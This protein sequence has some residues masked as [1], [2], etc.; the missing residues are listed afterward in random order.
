MRRVRK[1][2]EPPCLTACRRELRPEEREAGRIVA[3]DWD[4]LGDCA[5]NVRSALTHDQDFLCVYC[6]RR[7]VRPPQDHENQDPAELFPIHDGHLRSVQGHSRPGE[8]F[9]QGADA[10]AD[11]STLNLNAAPLVD[12][13]ARVIR[14]LR[15]RLSKD[16]SKGAIQR[17]LRAVT[18][19]GSEGLPPYAH[20][21]AAYL[22]KKLRC[23]RAADGEQ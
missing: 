6:G 22:S 21:A 15:V 13:R 5:K 1:G 12:D 9:P 8:V 10:L 18:I 14:D 17:L 19:A 3:S 4:K 11:T 16:D 7:L 20:V 23:R 2:S